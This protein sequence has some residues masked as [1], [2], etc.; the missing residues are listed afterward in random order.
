MGKLTAITVLFALVADFLFL[1][2]LLIKA[3][4]KKHARLVNKAVSQKNL[5]GVMGGE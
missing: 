1:P 4:E 5:A 3:E 2:P